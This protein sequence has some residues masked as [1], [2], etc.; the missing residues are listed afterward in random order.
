MLLFV[1]SYLFQIIGALWELVIEQSEL[2]SVKSPVVSLAFL[3]T[4]P[5]KTCYELK[6]L[7]FPPLFNPQKLSGNL[8]RVFTASN[9]NLVL[10]NW[11]RM[12]AWFSEK[13]SSYISS[14]GLGTETHYPEGLEVTTG[15]A[16]WWIKILER[17]HALFNY[18]H[19]LNQIW[20]TLQNND[21]QVW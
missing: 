4:I 19:I 14:Y 6:T 21:K 16:N 12:P 9:W 2:A 8:Q 20:E 5:W 18:Y 3:N 17:L 13:R 10:K 15:T 11:S 1:K 7:Q